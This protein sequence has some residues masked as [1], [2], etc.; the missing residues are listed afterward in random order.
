MDLKSKKTKHQNREEFVRYHNINKLYFVSVVILSDAECSVYQM[1]VDALIQNNNEP[2]KK[3]EIRQCFVLYAMLHTEFGQTKP[4]A[5]IR[6]LLFLLLLLLLH[7]SY[8]VCWHTKMSKKRENCIQLYVR[9]STTNSIIEII[10]R[11]SK[12]S[13]ASEYAAGIWITKKKRGKT[14]CRSEAQKARGL[15]GRAIVSLVGWLVARLVDCC[16]FVGWQS[17]IVNENRCCHAYYELFGYGDQ[18][19][20]ASQRTFSQ[21]D[22][23]WMVQPR[24]IAYQDSIMINFKC[25]YNSANGKQL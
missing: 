19:H 23:V 18:I 24:T 25:I 5:S 8:S 20:S 9:L 3:G 4:R 16:I 14:I 22:I 11:P 15:R 7:K 1:L 12:Y 6:Y 10:F 2:S 17:E 13:V 21:M